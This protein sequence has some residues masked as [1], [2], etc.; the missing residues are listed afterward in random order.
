MKVYISDGLVRHWFYVEKL[1]SYPELILDQF[2]M[3]GFMLKSLRLIMLKSLRLQQ[4]IFTLNKKIYS[5]FYFKINYNQNHPI[6]YYYFKIT[7]N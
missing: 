6:E 2:Y 1:I 7:S 4:V 5:K 3:F